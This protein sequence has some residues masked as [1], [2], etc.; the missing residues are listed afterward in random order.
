[1]DRGCFLSLRKIAGL[2]PFEKGFQG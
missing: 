2:F 1:M